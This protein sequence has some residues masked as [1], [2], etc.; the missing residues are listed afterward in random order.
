VVQKYQGAWLIVDNGC[1]KWA[2][3]IP[4]FKNPSTYAELSWS[5]WLL[6]S[7]QKG[8]E[9]VFGILKGCFRVLKI[10]IQIH[11]IEVTDR[12]W[13]ICCALHHFLLELDGLNKVAKWGSFRLERQTWKPPQVG[14]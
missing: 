3:T 2:I 10:G 11:G 9:C 6:E 4:P 12:V 1:L 8:V 13:L 5:K 7:M 14:Y